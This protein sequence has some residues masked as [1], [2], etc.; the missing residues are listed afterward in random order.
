MIK[1]RFFSLCNPKL[2]YPSFDIEA[3]EVK[4]LDLPSEAFLLCEEVETGDVKLKVGESVRTG[5]R[6]QVSENVFIIST[7]TGQL[8]EI[9]SYT[10]YLGKEYVQLSISVSEDIWDEDTTETVKDACFE[11]GRACL[12]SIPGR[13]DFSCFFQS[14]PPI[15]MAV[16][17]C[18]DEDILVQTRQ[19]STRTKTDSLI[20]GIETLKQVA[21]LGRVVLAVSPSQVPLFSDID[22]EII[23]IQ[24]VYPETL[25]GQIAAKILGNDL[26]PG[27]SF[28]EM[29][30]GFVSAEA[31][32]SLGE[33]FES[34]K[35]VLDKL[36]TVINK[37]NETALV[38]TRIGTPVKFV[39]EAVGIETFAGDRVVMGGPMR[40][41]A[42][43]SED[44]PITAD[45]DGIM[46][47]DKDQ[48]VLAEDVQ[49]INCGECVRSCPS[50]IPVNMLVRVVSKG[51][52]EDAATLYDL[53]SCIECG[54][55][56]YVCV[57]RIPI[58]QHIMLGK[59]EYAKMMAEAS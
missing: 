6:L 46:V 22:V 52:Y 38:K 59:Q 19:Y 47:Q 39:L 3:E 36:I 49:C 17:N 42:L 50:K 21:K 1:R 54:I 26:A 18:L 20:K 4:A 57:G 29:G 8:N 37:D 51:M 43:S 24:P 58:F 45:T 16:I 56:N 31:V 34:G 53:F 25:Q 15:N 2:K 12:G 41:R 10:G 35:M 48:V 55:C 14:Q 9:S 5:Q 40:G 13:S 7:V 32:V 44:F 30:I 33:T 28:E 27:K 11:S 23:R